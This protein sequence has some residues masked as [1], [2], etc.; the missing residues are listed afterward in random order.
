MHVS[1][2]NDAR[3]ELLDFAGFAQEFLRRNRDYRLQYAALGEP[4][5]LDPLAP[6]CREMARNW[7]LSFS[8]LPAGFRQVQSSDLACGSCAHGHRTCPRTA[9]S[10]RNCI[11]NDTDRADDH[12]RLFGRTRPAPC[13]G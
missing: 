4:A 13:F 12:L 2:R 1:V 11:P 9:W 10:L 7:G 8:D 3:D 5:G 6:Q